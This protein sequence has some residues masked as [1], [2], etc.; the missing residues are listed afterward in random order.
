MGWGNLGM[1]PAAGR[2]AEIHRQGQIS[3]QPFKTELGFHVFKI[4]EARDVKVPSFDE[5]K[6]QLARQ[7][8]NAQIE[9]PWS[10]CATRPRFSNPFRK[11]ISC[12]PSFC[13]A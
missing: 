10:N 4:E 6:Q 9:K 2:R 3:A 1:M 11:P 8:Q 12:V 5:A 7:M 13:A